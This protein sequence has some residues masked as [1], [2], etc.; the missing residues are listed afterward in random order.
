MQK[1]L[2]GERALYRCGVRKQDFWTSV[3]EEGQRVESFQPKAFFPR[4]NEHPPAAFERYHEAD[5]CPGSFGADPGAGGW[6]D[7]EVLKVTP[8]AAAAAIFSFIDMRS[9]AFC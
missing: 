3:Q 8:C 6:G 1:E 7:A 5:H 2:A 4:R 9:C